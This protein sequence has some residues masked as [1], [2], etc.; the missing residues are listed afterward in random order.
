MGFSEFM[1]TLTGKDLIC[2][3][4]KVSES[5][6]MESVKISE[7]FTFNTKSIRSTVD[8]LL[9]SPFSKRHE[10]Y[11]VWRNTISH[12]LLN[13]IKQSGG[14]TGSRWAEE[15]CWFN[16]LYVPVATV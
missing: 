9:Y 1:N 14:L 3:E 6:T 13:S 7:L 8:C 5:R 4:T 15:D 16:H 2:I 11:L 12:L 10:S